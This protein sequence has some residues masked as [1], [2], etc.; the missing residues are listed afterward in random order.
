VTAEPGQVVGAGQA[1]ITLAD[2]TQTEV[3]VAVPEQDAGRLS[4]GQP[5]KIT[6]WAG[7]RASVKGRIREIAGQA[8]PASRTYAVRIAVNAP[9]ETMRLGMTASV[10]LNVEGE[11]AP[12]VVP[13]TAVTE[14]DGGTVVFVVD[15]ANKVVRKT[16]VAVGDIADAGVRVAS[17]LQAGDM[18]VTAGVQFLHDGMRVRLPGE[19]Q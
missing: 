2:A 10:S 14:S 15:A 17:G 1:V 5:A 11:A 16:A 4:I 3:A 12:V 7:P 8:D 13:L 6:L 9:P 19:R 18:V